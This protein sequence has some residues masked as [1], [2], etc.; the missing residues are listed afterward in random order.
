MGSGQMT[1]TPIIVG[2]CYRSGTS[3]LRRM[4]DAHSRIHCGPEVKFFADFYGNY[5]NVNRW[6]R[7]S[8][9]SSV[10]TLGLDDD[11]LLELFAPAYI[12]AHERAA[13]R[14][15][16]ARW[17]DKSPDN[18]VYANQWDR[19]L[20]GRLWFVHVIRHPLDTLASMI[21]AGFKG[22]LPQNLEGKIEVYRDYVT[23]GLEYAKE[24][25]ERSVE[26]R[27]EELITDPQSVLTQFLERVG[28]S[29][30]PAMV[31]GF[32]AADRQT[33]LE[34]HKI[35]ELSTVVDESVG[36]WRRDLGRKDRKAAIEGLG[37]LATTLGYELSD[38]S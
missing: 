19:V 22:A 17:A 13:G 11:D 14:R 20:A 26:I 34:D 31:T 3:L 7:Q 33:G 23:H 27:Y 30:E 16:K 8:F 18:V 9:F 35:A 25:P 4:L 2:G 21:E 6:Q 12:E 1:E 24:H 37:P 10:R 32:N 38:R 5:L 28:E 15:G 36:R 29:F